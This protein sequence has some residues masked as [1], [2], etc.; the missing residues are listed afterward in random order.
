MLSAILLLTFVL[1][2]GKTVQAAIVDFFTA[3]NADNN[4]GLSPTAFEEFAPLSD[5]I[6]T[7]VVWSVL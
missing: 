4:I 5:G 3:A 6:V 2:G 7:G 1:A